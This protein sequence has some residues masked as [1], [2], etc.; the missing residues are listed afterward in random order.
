ML[1]SAI[2]L[3]AWRATQKNWHN[4]WNTFVSYLTILSKIFD[5]YHHT[6]ELNVEYAIKCCCTRR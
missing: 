3:K 6:T 1:S 5:L 2:E 4:P